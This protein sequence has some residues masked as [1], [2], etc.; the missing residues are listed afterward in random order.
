MKKHYKLLTALF[1]IGAFVCTPKAYA[2]DNI[3]GVK[4]SP[5]SNIVTL[6][7]SMSDESTFTIENPNT[8]S[9]ATYEIY[10]APY[11]Y[12]HSESEDNYLLGFSAENSYTQIVRWISFKDQSGN[13]VPKLTTTVDANSSKEITYRIS[14]PSSI[15]NGG[16]YA[17]IFTQTVNNGSEGIKTSARTGLVL[18][19]RSLGDSIKSAE[20][21]DVALTSSFMANGDIHGTVRVKNTGNIDLD[22]KTTLKVQGIFGAT[23]YENTKDTSVIPEIEL[24]INTGWTDDEGKNI[25]PIIG[26]F[27]VTFKTAINSLGK[28]ETITN[29]TLIY[30][31]W[32]I[33]LSIILLT[34]LIIWII[35][36]TKRH[37]ERRSRRLV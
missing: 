32:A 10:A 23:Y 31:I 27:K 3:S 37:K 25:T 8:S 34:I 22:V 7:P 2:D 35:F 24:K 36:L 33:I 19:G 20:I 12:S 1:V 6:S 15:P 9:A 28:E 13:F 18:Y 29:V 11:S 21:S 16:Q 4:I 30:P 17:V 26:L 14:T 5:P